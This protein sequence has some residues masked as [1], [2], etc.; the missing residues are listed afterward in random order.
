M[1]EEP[2]DLLSRHLH[3]LNDL[4]LLDLLILSE[5]MTLSG[6]LQTTESPL[7]HLL[8]HSWDLTKLQVLR[9]NWIL[10]ITQWPG[11]TQGR[12]P[13]THGN[14]MCVIRGSC[15]VWIRASAYGSEG[16]EKLGISSSFLILIWNVQ[17]CY[18]KAPFCEGSGRC[19]REV[20]IIKPCVYLTIW[21]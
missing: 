20:N 12:W 4:G 1:P 18:M 11:P 6:G 2:T 15:E 19:L 21:V 16:G 17:P 3:T 14:G 10:S 8:P 7:T 5:T 13:E 9:C